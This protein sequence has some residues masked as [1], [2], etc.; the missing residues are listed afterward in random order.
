MHRLSALV[1]AA[2]LAAPSAAAAEPDE[3]ASP[4]PPAETVPAAPP[5]ETVPAAPPPDQQ[6][7]PGTAAL[8]IT[9]A[10]RVG[11]RRV[12]L[13]GQALEVRGSVSRFVEGET[14]HVTVR[15]GRRTLRSVTKPVAAGEIGRAHV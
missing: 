7:P 5:P 15:R 9:G 3:A 4:A 12:A 1:A 6:P 10:H 13:T 2:L 14:V 11:E 8:G